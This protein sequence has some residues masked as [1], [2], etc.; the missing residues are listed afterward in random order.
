[1]Q[2]QIE[3]AQASYIGESFEVMFKLH[4]SGSPPD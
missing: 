2:Q 1:V 3:H 4:I